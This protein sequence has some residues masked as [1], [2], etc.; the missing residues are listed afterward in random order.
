MLLDRATSLAA[1]P[2]CFGCREAGAWA[3]SSCLTGLGP[4]LNAEPIP[5]VDRVR[6]PWAYDGLARD[7]VLALKLRGRRPAAQPLATALARS[8]QREGSEVT[9]ITWVPGRKPETRR[10]GF[11]HAEVIARELARLLG[12]PVTS[13]L[14]R[15]GNRPDQTTLSGVARRQNLKGAFM[16]SS[17]TERV[18]LVDDLVTT[19]ATA[20]ACARALRDCGATYV[21]VAAPC[22]A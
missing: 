6:T 19:G 8:I 1:R 15:T 11:D 10:R 12:L 16:A 22:R 21:E 17:A 2:R 7:L 14:G 4:P 5:C 9:A 20:E 3:C 13:L 18:M